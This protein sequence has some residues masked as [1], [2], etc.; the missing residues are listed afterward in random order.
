[1]NRIAKIID[2]RCQ[3]VDLLRI[4]VLVG[5]VHKRQFLPEIV[6]CH[7]LVCDEHKILD[8]LRRNIPVIRFDVDRFSLL[9]QNNFCFREIKID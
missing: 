9:I 8:D 4:R 7:C 1:M 5:T 2:K 6:L 3:L